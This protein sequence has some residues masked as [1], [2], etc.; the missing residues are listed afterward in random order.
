VTDTDI[1]QEIEASGLF[2]PEWYVQNYSDVAATGMDP[3]EHFTWLGLRLYRDPGPGFS[4]ALYL[5]GYPDVR[6]SDLHPLLHFIR[7]GAAEG[8]SGT[9]APFKPGQPAQTAAATDTTGF[10]P[11]TRPQD[12]HWVARRATDA[13]MQRGLRPM[14]EIAVV[15]NA[16][17]PAD[18][19][20]A[21]DVLARIA[22]PHD[23][24]LAGTETFDFSNMPAQSVSVGYLGAADPPANAREFVRFAGSGALVD[25]RAVLWL[26]PSDLAD[27]T[28]FSKAAEQMVAQLEPF[29]DDADW[30][31]SGP[32]VKP[33]GNQSDPA[34]V[35]ALK[36]I[37]P[38]LGLHFAQTDIP[39]VTGPAILIK[40]LLLRALATA[41]RPVEMTPDGAQK[42]F[43]GRATVLGVLAQLAHQAGMQTATTRKAV[44]AQAAERSVKTVAFYLPQF[45]PIPENDLWW[46]KGFTEWSNVIRGRQLFRHH[47][48][49]RVPADLGFYDLR[50]EDTQTA[51]ADLARQF[52]INGFCY[53]YYWFN[54]KKLL[55]QPIEQM[56][57]STRTDAGFCVCWANENWSRNWDG[58]NRHVLMK[59]DYSLD[60]NRDLIREL[61]P[62]MKDPRWIRHNGKPVMMVYRISI[63]PN[64]METARIW[65]EECRAAG[66]GEIHLCAVRFGLEMLEGQPEEHGLDAYVMFPPHEAPRED[67]R[68][69]V[70]DLHRDFGGEVFSYDAVVRGDLEK[71]ETGYDWPVHRGAMLGWDN[72]ARRLTD[73]RIFHGATP[74]GFRT[75]IKGILEQ[76]ARHAPGADTLMFINAWNEWAEGTYLE[77]DQRWGTGYLEAFASAARAVPGARLQTVAPGTALQPRH[78]SH[79]DHVGN[80]L[81]RDGAALAPPVWY[82]G[83]QSVEP[84][85]PTVLVCAH[86]AGHQLFGGERSLLDVIQAMATL[87]VNIVVTLPSDNNAA[88]LDEIRKHC[89]GIYAFAYPQWMDARQRYGWLTLSFADILARHA[90]DVVHA[91]TIVLIEPLEAGRALGRT[92]VTHSRELIS[93]DEKLLN[94]MAVPAP[95]IISTVFERSDWVIGNSQ[96]TCDLFHR[97]GQTLYVPNAVTL[98]TFDMGNKFGNTIKFGIVS[99]NI[100][101]KGV[102]DFVEAAR[103]AAPLTDRAKFVVIGPATD[104]TRLWQDEVARGVRPDNLVFAGYADTPRAAMSQIN[105]LLNLSSFAESFGRTVAEAMAARRPVIGYDW[106][107]LRELI[108]DGETG[109]LVPYRDID[110]VVRAVVDLCTASERIPEMG[111]AGRACVTAHF[112]QDSLRTALAKSYAQVLGRPMTH[113]AEAETETGAVDT[114]PAPALIAQTIGAA[115]RTTVV[116]AVYNA[117]D[118]VRACLASVLRHTDLDR[119]RV[120][121]IDD[122]SPEPDVAPMLEEF[123]G[124]PGLTIRRNDPNKGYT[125]TINIGIRAAGE[126]DVV[127]LNSDT[128]VTPRWLEGLRAT[129]YSR[130]KVAT[131]TAMSDNAG[132]FS[133]PTFNAYCPKPDHLSLDEY[134]LLMV[135]AGFDCTPP[136]VPTGSGFCMYIRRA[137]IDACGLFDEEG[138]PRGYGEE[139]DFCMRAMK[140]GWVNL[141]SP[142]SFVY[143]ERTASFKGEKT[144][145]VQAGLDV[146]TKRYPDY[147]P[148]VKEAFAAPDMMALREKTV[149]T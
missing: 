26:S 53:Y 134:A 59:Q 84:D 83:A 49:P 128:V 141:I 100:P 21:R 42:T 7:Y 9:P 148:L 93:L 124:T 105:V 67:L 27:K 17:A 96:A 47:Y 111:E 88:Y 130:D 50:L 149:L 15:V 33:L 106:G 97:P 74:Y 62:M 29:A 133:F 91:N 147:A 120:L 92:T 58:Q 30:G 113:T 135:E 37:L 81:A 14:A 19:L 6:E 48:Q 31:L 25:Y 131:V 46:G 104:Q 71:Y 20:A 72:T 121:V 57:R 109:Y 139:N 68:D 54:G 44:P 143:H 146:V 56:A 99:S 138:F 73:A 23:V 108:R 70:I 5:A 86:V 107:A 127:L 22:T 41:L 103:R 78:G 145:L 137:L 8:R 77:P 117:A 95:E 36:V 4:A 64:W 40:P 122:G 82:A 3:F 87:P 80:P 79:L 12:A 144:K 63:I 136:E 11:S 35:Y 28:G 13:F 1:A 126:D 140:A 89:L 119:H 76:D 123:E 16:T 85:R 24:F 129:A 60:S 55:N 39:G 94:R 2:D 45:H 118:E 116:I 32:A 52:G 69:K 51:Q 112:S 101:A 98:E 75:W 38:R 43:P 90:V 61:I 66:L 142:W 115:P 18:W 125:R 102:T 65:R 34:L 114:P 110:A 10:A 132:A